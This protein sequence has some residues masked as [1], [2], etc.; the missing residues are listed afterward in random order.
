LRGLWLAQL[1]ER[2]CEKCREL[3][4]E[5]QEQIFRTELLSLPPGGDSE[6]P[7]PGLLK[8]VGYHVGWRFG[9]VPEMRQ[10]IIA[11][12]LIAEHLPAIKDV[13]YMAEWGSLADETLCACG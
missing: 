5:I 13:E 6:R 1:L 12:I 8:A 2:D 10:F 4:K 3:L 11:F 7:D 9:Q